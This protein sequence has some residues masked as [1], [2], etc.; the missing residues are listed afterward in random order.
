M[1][2]VRCGEAVGGFR[3]H[4][5]SH[6]PSFVFILDWRPDAVRSNGWKSCRRL[7]SMADQ[8]IRRGSTKVVHSF[9]HVMSCYVIF[10][11]VPLSFLTIFPFLTI[12]Y[13]LFSSSISPLER[14]PRLGDEMMGSRM[15]SQR[16]G[17]LLACLM[18]SLRCILHVYLPTT[19]THGHTLYTLHTHTY[20]GMASGRSSPHDITNFFCSQLAS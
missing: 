18:V 15:A 9:V 2:R 11:F 5:H 10:L 16:L 4:S 13:L 8:S 17:W 20:S 19:Y 3:S 12:S 6:A 7:T 1:W 14:L